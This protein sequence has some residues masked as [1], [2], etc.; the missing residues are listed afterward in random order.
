MSNRAHWSRKGYIPFV[1]VVG[2]EADEFPT[3]EQSPSYT[4]TSTQGLTASWNLCCCELFRIVLVRIVCEFEEF[5]SRSDARVAYLFIH[6]FQFLV[7]LLSVAALFDALCCLVYLQSYCIWKGLGFFI[8][9]HI[10]S[11]Q[12]VF[13]PNLQGLC[14]LSALL[15]S[16]SF[17]HYPHLFHIYVLVQLCPLCWIVLCFTSCLFRSL[18]ETHRNFLQVFKVFGGS[19]VIVMSFISSVI[20][21]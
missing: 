9:C 8:H 5:I 14:S 1:L 17:P 19:P 16:P 15:C 10:V 13:W 20:S 21:F 6:T 7:V 3:T 4:H 11:I 18:W 2:L 12:S